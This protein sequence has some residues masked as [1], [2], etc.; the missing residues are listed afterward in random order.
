MGYRFQTYGINRGSH[1][2]GIYKAA[3]HPYNE[4]GDC[5]KDII[6]IVY[7]R[8]ISGTLRSVFGLFLQ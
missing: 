3:H 2:M 8:W 5:W 7:R 1:Q 6:H 4:N